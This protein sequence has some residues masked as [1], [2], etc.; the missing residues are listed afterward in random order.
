[1]GTY[2]IRMPDMGEGIAEVELVG[3]RVAGRVNCQQGFGGVAL[4]EHG[5]HLLIPALDESHMAVDLQGVV[6]VPQQRLRLCAGPADA[7]GFR[8]EKIDGVHLRRP[9]LDFEAISILLWIRLPADSNANPLRI[10]RL[11][12][13]VPDSP[14]AFCVSVTGD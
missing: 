9:R 2:V 6:L 10:G 1:M 7:P 13:Q 11:V 8:R 3:W 12:K 5:H 4:G 14:L